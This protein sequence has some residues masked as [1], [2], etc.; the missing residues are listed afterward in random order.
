[1]QAHYQHFVFDLY[2]TLVDIHTE[3]DDPALWEKMALILSF[4]GARYE[5]DELRWEYLRSVQEQQRLADEKLTRLDM[6]GPGEPEIRK[7]WRELLHMKGFDADDERI[8]DICSLFRALSIRRLRLFPDALPL[9]QTLRRA[10]KGVY[11][12]SNAQAAFTRPEIRYLGLDGLF[13]RV[14]LS[15]EWGARKPSPAFF[16]LLEK[17]AGLPLRDTLMIGNDPAC[18][19]LG[20]EKAGIDSLFIFTGWPQ[21]PAALPASCREIPRLMDAMQFI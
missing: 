1:M 16:S 2:G 6:E 5:A 10:G 3:E 9:L 7:V 19:C 20:A 13:D 14:F 15:S 8:E 21:R 12:L 18:D 11:L 17:E 4:Q